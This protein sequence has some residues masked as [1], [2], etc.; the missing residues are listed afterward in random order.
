MQA[1]D[2]RAITEYGLPGAVLMENAG[3]GVFHLLKER[4]PDLADKKVIVFSGK[5]NNG[6]DG[7]VIARALM[8]LGCRVDLLLLGQVASLKADAKLHAGIAIK[9]GVPVHEIDSGSLKKFQHSVRHADILIDAI[10]GTGFKPPATGFFA[11]VIDWVN[12]AE[13]FIVAVDIPSG[14]DAD[15]G[16]ILGPHVQADL[17]AAFGCLKRSHC[18]Y[19]AATS[20]GDVALVDIGLP[21][22]SVAEEKVRVLSP[23][24]DDIRRTLAPRPEDAH[25]GSFGHVLVVAGSVGKGGAA[26]LTALAALRSGCGLVTLALPES[27]QKAVEF[28]PLEVMTVPLRETSTG[29]ISLDALDALVEQF[30][31]KA[32]IAIGPGLS[33]DPATVDLLGRLL[34]L[35]PCP[36]VIDA[37]AINGLAASGFELSGLP[38]EAVLTP[39]PREMS[40]ISGLSVEAVQADRIGAATD[41]ASRHRVHL[42]L[43][44][45]ASVI[46]FPDGSA[47]INPTGNPGMATAGSG[48]V[49]TGIIAGFIAQGLPVSQ[50]ALAG[51]WCHGAAGDRA[52]QSTGRIALI[53][54]DLLDMLPATLTSLTA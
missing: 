32:A 12:S 23:E 36:L 4:Y 24:K 16:Q 44:G 51:T 15:T 14:L 49:L 52:A 34:P 29:A 3:R 26:G 13:K 30:A 53:A 22:Q 7:F 18:L 25:K 10:F 48:D 47:W 38:V 42:V 17:T 41:F 54:S 6:G 19:P 40:R 1:I 37:D 33:T 31:G 11:E 28:H 9:A 39:H 8:D 35:A 20:M 45:A 46:A 2:H 5:G 43:K 21:R 50:A 27:V